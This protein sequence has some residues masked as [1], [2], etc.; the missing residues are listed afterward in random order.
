MRST[1]NPPQPLPLTPDAAVSPPLPIPGIATTHAAPIPLRDRLK[2][3]GLV[4]LL[5]G[6]GI[7]TVFIGAKLLYRNTET[8]LQ[9]IAAPSELQSPS[10]R[11]RVPVVTAT[12]PLSR[13]EATPPIA[14]RPQSP[15]RST[16]PT[17]P[18]RNQDFSAVAQPETV[19]VRPI[20]AGSP[21][22]SGQTASPTPPASTPAIAQRR[23]PA[24]SPPSRP[25]PVELI[26]ALLQAPELSRTPGAIAVAPSIPP[27]TSRPVSPTAAPPAA[28][29][30]TAAPP[31][32]APPTVA[33]A[34]S[35]SARPTARP[36]T[37]PTAPAPAVPTPFTVEPPTARPAPSPIGVSPAPSPTVAPIAAPPSPIA[38]PPPLRDRIPL[39]QLQITGSTR[40]SQAQLAA[41]VRQV[42]GLS[43]PGDR[44]PTAT[45][46]SLTPAELVQIS[47][48]ITKLYTERGFI[49]SGAFVPADVLTGATPEIRVVEGSL[50][51]INVQ[52]QRP[53]F[54]WLGRP[55]SPN[56]VRRR[57][58]RNIQTPLQIDQLADAVRLLEQDPMIS[59]ITTE[60]A[61]GTTLG[62][63]TLNVKVRQAPPLRATV[64][65]DNGRAPSVGTFRQQVGLSHANL[66]GLGDRLQVGYNRS[67]GSQSFD[68]GFAVPINPSNGT[69]SFA[70]TN[71]RGEVI[72]EPFRALGITSRSQNY[73]IALR[74]PILQTANE[75]FAL[76][77]RGTHYRNEGVFL[78]AFNEGVAIPFPARGSDPDGKTRI[79]AIRFGQEW[80]KRGERD[81]FSLQS[82]FSFGVSAFGATQLQEPPD[83]RFFSW[84]GR[85]FWVHSF[86]P[87]TL[88]AL[89][90][91][92]Q[93]AN[94]P[95]V[96][97]E[98]LSLGGIDT[99]RGYRTGVLLADNAWFA[100]AEFYLPVLR[101]PRWQGVL[102]VVPF[103]DAG[104]GWNLGFDQPDPSRLLSV[105]L[106]LQWKMGDNFRA[107]LDWGVPLIN[108]TATNGQSL[109]ESVFFSIIYTP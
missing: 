65:I 51:A 107:R 47:E 9:P 17:P 99:V 35:S 50:E 12:A 6:M 98:Q 109:R 93:F 97:V 20:P 22:S 89:K 52:V 82:E 14:A 73:E 7:G 62:K 77:I 105:G 48:A 28:A 44:S 42:T 88:F 81:V 10:V 15:P 90:G 23:S 31:T 21:P 83:G 80:L 70:Y 58:Q 38:T 61:P 55:L 25:F 30:P 86:A 85:G 66:L 103:I 104:R 75:L 24:A 34:P 54:L 67:A 76:S 33:P 87:D 36:T 26:A 91:Q 101:I 45:T 41:I 100:S 106:G 16:P 84:Q 59:S 32:A 5:G 71:S 13:P 29:P 79:T 40:F 57:L 72:E 37:R 102:Q 27:A 3:V 60:L 96:P 49:N 108:S 2:A 39:E 68:I 18:R 8:S 4:T 64:S 69:L 94:R 19:A 74:Q 46:Q 95:L 56:Y 92:L 1:N 11:D 78:E 53:N 43:N 63:S